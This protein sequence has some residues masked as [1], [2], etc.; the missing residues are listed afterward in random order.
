MPATIKFELSTEP[1]TTAVSNVSAQMGVT[2]IVGAQYVFICT[3][4]CWIKVGSNPTA[5]A[6][7]GNAFV[8]A[9]QP[10]W[11][12]NHNGGGKVAVIRDS[13]DGTA[14]LYRLEGAA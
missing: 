13:V 9:K 3:V 4:D 8:P 7:D 12:C 6:A 1:E 2:M 5:S 11:L 14:C 10:V